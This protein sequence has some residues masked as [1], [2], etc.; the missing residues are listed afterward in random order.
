MNS[1]APPD[2][3]SASELGGFAEP[4]FVIVIGPGPS[5]FRNSKMARWPP[6]RAGEMTKPS[7]PGEGPV[8]LRWL[9]ALRAPVPPRSSVLPP[10][11]GN[12]A[13]EALKADQ[14]RAN[15][16][17]EGYLERTVIDGHV[18]AAAIARH[19]DGDTAAIQTIRG[20][21]DAGSLRPDPLMRKR[22]DGSFRNRPRR[23]TSRARLPVLDF[24]PPGRRKD[25]PSV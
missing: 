2:F 18:N 15:K 3:A 5:L 12:E 4:P 21:H 19:N 22:R 7:P 6:C 14:E 17:E 20:S 1:M 24:A 9:A 8:G 25:G 11:D 10:P 13:Y 16:G 23:C